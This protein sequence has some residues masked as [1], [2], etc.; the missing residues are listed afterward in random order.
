[1]SR[2]L[3]AGG[4]FFLVLACKPKSYSQDDGDAGSGD[5][6]GDDG[7]VCVCQI[8][9][10]TTDVTIPCGEAACVG[11]T[12]YQC[13]SEGVPLP[14]VAGACG[15]PSDA[16]FLEEGQCLPSCEGRCGVSD[17]CGGT[18]ACADGVQ[19]NPNGTCGNGCDN[20]PGDICLIDDAG[21]TTCCASPYTCHAGD[22]GASTCCALNAEGT[23]AQDTDC[24]SYPTAHCSTATHTCG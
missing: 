21:P 4:L 7:G 10:A 3:V 23:C 17:T 9:T 19:C 5:D 18:C 22:S 11:E 8:P 14:G 15:G 13:S 24:C 20:G 2:W 12:A 1:M 16:G 6:S